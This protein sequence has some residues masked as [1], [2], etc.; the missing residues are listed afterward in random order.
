MDSGIRPVVLLQAAEA[1]R[2]GMNNNP[3][4]KK[5]GGV[6]A[7]AWVCLSAG[8]AAYQIAWHNV[9]LSEER[10]G[11]GP[12]LNLRNAGQWIDPWETVKR[13]SIEYDYPDVDVNLRELKDTVEE[14]AAGYFYS[15][16]EVCYGYYLVYFT[17]G[18]MKYHK[19]RNSRDKTSRRG[20]YGHLRIYDSRGNPVRMF[21]NFI[22]ITVST[23]K[24]DWDL[25]AYA[26]EICSALLEDLLEQADSD[27]RIINGMLEAAGPVQGKIT[28]EARIRMGKSLKD[29]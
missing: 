22:W 7:A 3:L 26:S 28:R 1:R 2:R 14:S 15:P 12:L 9:E 21:Q 11:R 6:L 4:G 19:A 29:P 24:Q 23:R 27:S 13:G 16:D 8:C 25:T 5:A 10:P 18:A 20:L 17:Y